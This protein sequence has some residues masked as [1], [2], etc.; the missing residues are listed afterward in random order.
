MTIRHYRTAMLL[1]GLVFSSL[2]NVG[3]AE[4]AT[5]EPVPGEGGSGKAQR[6]VLVVVWD[7]M[8]PDFVSETNTPVLWKLTREGVV[9]RNHHAVYPSSTLVNGVA[10][11]TGAYPAH[12]GIV[13][14]REYRPAINNRKA[15]EADDWRVVRKGDDLSGGKYVARPTVAELV[16]KSGRRTAIATSKGVGLLHDRHV[17]GNGV[18]LFSGKSVPPGAVKP[19]AARLGAFPLSDIPD[20]RCDSWTTTALLKSIWKDG[21][22]DFSLL[23]LAEPDGTEHKLTPGSPAALSA[24]RVS[25]NNLSRVLAA[26]DRFHVREQTD[27]FIVSDHGFSTIERAIDLRKVLREAGFDVVT[28]FKSNP[29][30]GQIM[31][32]GNGGTVLFYLIRGPAA[33]SPSDDE[34]LRRLVEF[35]QHSDFAGVLFTKQPM[36]GTFGLDQVKIDSAHAPDIVMGFRWNDSKNPFGLPGMIDADW[37]RRPGQGTHATLSRFDMHN[38]LI[39]AGP[40]FQ[41]GITDELPTGNVDLA[42]T[43]L[44]ILGIAS[45][46]PMDG[47]VLVEAM[48]GRTNGYPKPETTTLEAAREFP[49]G[50]WRQTVQ[51]SRVG[52][53]L[54]F[55][56]SSGEFKK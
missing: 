13:A 8:R 7:G 9:F 26:L 12:S 1:L 24:V 54:Y 50:Q 10:M 38:T 49:E 35:L 45:P 36:Q 42:P 51:V 56:E 46:Q 37:N 25:D 22:P 32:V 18:I 48:N 33:A 14:N 43:I 6:R 20:R 16:R 47:R 23:W 29:K 21:I 3:A 55:D 27:I 2:G 30:P 41:R 28:E 4:L 52:T 44:H 40:D 53:T 17:D 34:V 5:A 31:M 19:I 15:F 39:A 11:A